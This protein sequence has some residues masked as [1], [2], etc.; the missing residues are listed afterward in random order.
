MTHNSILP[1]EMGRPFG[2][3]PPIDLSYWSPDP[4]AEVPVHIMVTR[5]SGF[6]DLR[7]LHWKLVWVVNVTEDD[8]D[9]QIYHRR[10]EVVQEI[11]CNHLTNW[12]A[13]TQVETASSKRFN[14]RNVV[15][16]MTLAQR[17]ELERLAAGVRVEEPNGVWNCQDW[18]VTVLQ[19][20]E[21]A[22]LVTRNEWMSAVAWARNGGGE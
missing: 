5:I 11:G 4:D 9:V 21:Q 19:Q 8:G 17:K 13:V 16:T 20:A 15:A 6:T 18:I 10:L 1:N 22:G 7:D 12:G 3:L 14:P 2:R